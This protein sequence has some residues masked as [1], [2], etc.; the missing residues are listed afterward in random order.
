MMNLIRAEYRKLKSTQ[1][2]FW[3]FVLALGLTALFVIGPIASQSTGELQ[4]TVRDV[5]LA[6]VTAYVG[7]FVL[8][9]LGVT[10]EFRYQTITPTLLATP[11]R[12]TLM[13]AKMISYALVGAVYAGT[14]VVTTVAIALPWLNGKGVDVSFDRDHIWGALFGV[15]AA[16]V[17]F[18]LLGLGFG[19]LV[20]N[21][22]VA[23]TIG[24]IWVL[25]AERLIFSIPGIRVARPYLPTGG[26]DAITSPHERVG[27]GVQLLGTGAGMVVILVWAF[28]FAVGGAAYS[29]NRDIT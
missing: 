19:A 22:I 17:L 5:F 29:M 27:G 16:V 18:S 3:L 13:G 28:A 23:V 11:S 21:Q 15:F 8:G 10:T 12:W 24:V 1:V 9:V 26:L 20:R 4:A 6:P 2:W 25:L 7:A 14:C